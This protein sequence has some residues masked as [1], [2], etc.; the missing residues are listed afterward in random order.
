[1]DTLNILVIE[2]M[3][4]DSEPLTKVLKEKEGI[5][6][7]YQVSRTKNFILEI[8][9]ALVGRIMR[10]SEPG[11]TPIPVKPPEYEQIKL[12]IQSPF[13]FDKVSLTPEAK[14]EFDKFI[15]SIKT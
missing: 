7:K 6:I 13:E 14:Q 8:S 4:S 10:P 15:Q 5:E 9:P 2:D 11:N 3:V 12:D 1:M